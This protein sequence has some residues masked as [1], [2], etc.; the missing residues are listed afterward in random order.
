MKSI[1]VIGGKNTGQTMDILNGIFA[2]WNINNITLTR[3]ENDKN[4]ITVS[5][6]TGSKGKSNFY[7]YNSDSNKLSDFSPVKPCTVITFGLNPKACVT[8]SSV[9]ENT[10]VCCIQ[11]PLPTLDGSVVIQQEFSVCVNKSSYSPCDVLG[12]VSTALV[13]NFP[14]EMFSGMI[15]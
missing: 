3:S 13:C 8:L 15:I 1:G 12:A 2:V 11:R 7:L 6:S 9:N 14:A 5:G 10:L 4:F